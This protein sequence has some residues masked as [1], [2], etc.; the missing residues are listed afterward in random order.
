MVPTIA[1]AVLPLRQQPATTPLPLST[2]PWTCLCAPIW[3]GA[4]V[5]E[6]TL[7]GP[8]PPPISEVKGDEDGN[9]GNGGN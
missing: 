9:D 8:W 1:M 2:S 5:N 4:A 7:A 6:G 3:W